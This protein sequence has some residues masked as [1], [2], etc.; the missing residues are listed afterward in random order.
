MSHP[1]QI[2]GALYAAIAAGNVEQAASYLAEDA[3]FFITPEMPHQKSYYKG[4]S[5]FVQEV[6]VKLK[7]VY[8]PDIRAET[9]ALMSGGDQLTVIGKYHGTS[10][11]DRVVDIYFVHSWTVRDG[12]AQELRVMTD[13]PSWTAALVK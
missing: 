10:L 7:A 3:D 6:W 9:V 2:I 4:R 13:A 11:I 5:Q 8:V 12:L 1:K